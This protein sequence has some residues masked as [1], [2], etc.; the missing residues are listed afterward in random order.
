[1]LRCVWVWDD[2]E[3]NSGIDSVILELS[4]EEHFVR[5]SGIQLRVHEKL[6]ASNFKGYIVLVE[7]SLQFEFE[8]FDFV[9]S[10]N[11]KVSS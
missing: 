7:Q 9:N 2:K 4:V 8:S 5:C 3:L 10:H 1:M 6:F 11:I